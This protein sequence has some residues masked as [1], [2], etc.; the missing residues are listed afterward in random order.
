MHIYQSTYANILTLQNDST[1]HINNSINLFGEYF[2]QHTVIKSDNISISANISSNNSLS[3]DYVELDHVANISNLADTAY[4]S[5]DEGGNTNWVFDSV[6]IPISVDTFMIS[7]VSP[8]FNNSNG[9]VEIHAIGGMGNY[10]YSIYK[11]NYQWWYGYNNQWHNWQSDSVYAGLHATTYQVRILDNYGCYHQTSFSVGSPPY[12]TVSHNITQNVSCNGNSDASVELSATG[13][14]L[15]TYT[16][17]GVTEITDTVFYDSL[18][19]GAYNVEIVDTAGCIL[20]YP[21]TITEPNVLNLNLN[22]GNSIIECYG[23]STGVINFI[24]TGGT[25]PYTYYVNAINSPFG[26]WMSDTLITDVD[27]ALFRAGHYKVVVIDA[28]GCE[29]ENVDQIYQPNVLDFYFDD[30]SNVSCYGFS[31]GII[32]IHIND[33][34][35]NVAG[36]PPYNY[37]WS[38]GVNVDNIS[39]LPLGN[40]GLTVTDYF[41]CILDTTFEISQPDSLSYYYS[42]TNVSC[43]GYNNGEIINDSLQGGVSPYDFAWLP[44][45]ET[46]PSLTQLEADIYTINISDNN[47]CETN[48]IIEITEP[49]QL[50]VNFAG[51]NIPCYGDT[52]GQSTASVSGGTFP[53]SYNWVHGD[54]TETITGI[55]AGLYSVVVEDSEGCHTDPLIQTIEVTERPEIIIDFTIGT[56]DCTGT[57]GNWAATQVT[58]GTPDNSGANSIYIY[59]WSNGNTA[60]S[61]YSISAGWH[62]LTVTDSLSC[63]MEDSIFVGPL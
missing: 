45:G 38:T 22:D 24:A 41:N 46:T 37:L 48:I 14:G 61:I 9:V 5:L 44:N 52:I 6:Y 16:F 33:L 29:A 12:V 20:N 23:D 60:D 3:V 42:T 55:S 47:N 8:C 34:S 13:A 15:L 21:I 57:A 49:D 62:F 27:S 43:N 18:A 2:C 26:D 19:Q 40:Y 50:I 39:N 63:N 53:Y 10:Q 4:Y 58:G 59:N 7:D 31:D 54:S 28:H 51:S 1:Q 56:D 25:T 17:Q 30:F 35:N 11:Y 32:D 36:T